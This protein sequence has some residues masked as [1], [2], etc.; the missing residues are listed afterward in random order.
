MQHTPCAWLLL[1]IKPITE[2]LQQGTDSLF[3]NTLCCVYNDSRSFTK[4]HKDAK[5]FKLE[6]ESAKLIPYHHNY[7]QLALSKSFNN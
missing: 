2:V 1:T 5:P 7:L 4:M 3:T 6:K